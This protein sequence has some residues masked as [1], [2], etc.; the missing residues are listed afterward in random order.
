MQIR[1]AVAAFAS[2][3]VLASSG[4]YAASFAEIGDATGALP[5]QAAVGVGSL[6]SITGA[7]GF[8]NDADVFRITITD[9][10]SFSA[11]TVGGIPDTQLFLFEL[12]TNNIAF[13]FYIF[14]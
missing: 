2:A 4:A 7:I 13:S 10:A 14:S 1:S 6:D 3:I 8:N 12:S 5:G 9:A 11:R